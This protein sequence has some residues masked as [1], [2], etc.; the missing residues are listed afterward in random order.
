MMDIVCFHICCV[1]PRMPTL[2]PAC[3]CQR[4]LRKLYVVLQ[5][6]SVHNYSTAAGSTTMAQHHGPQQAVANT[7]APAQRTSIIFRA[8]V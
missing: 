1:L 2:C 6:C 7:W 5:H 8:A 3:R 4:L